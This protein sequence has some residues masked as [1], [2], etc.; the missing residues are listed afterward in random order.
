LMDDAFDLIF[1]D[2]STGSLAP[3][4][5]HRSSWKSRKQFVG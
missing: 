5:R 1:V 2:N 4:S 3:S